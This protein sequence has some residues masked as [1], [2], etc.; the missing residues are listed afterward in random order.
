MTLCAVIFISVSAEQV[1]D[2]R[3]GR[4]GPVARDLSELEIAQITDLANATGKAPWLILGFRTMLVGVAMVTVY[5]EPNVT[6]ERLNRGRI[7]HLVADDPPLVS[8]RSRW[9][10]RKTASYAYIPL[11]G[12]P[13]EIADEHDLGWPFEVAGEIDDEMLTGLVTFVRSRPAIPGIPEGSEPRQVV[14]WPL[15]V[16]ARQGDEFIAAFRNGGSEVFRVWLI[17]KDGRWLVTKWDAAVA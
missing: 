7:L 13:R 9:K 4:F 16:I 11:G 15:S 3:I 1:T 10:V 14:S 12:R 17:R 2:A 8:Q 6:T 5:L